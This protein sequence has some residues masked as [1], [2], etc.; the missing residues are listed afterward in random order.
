MRLPSFANS[1]LRWLGSCLFP[2]AAGALM[3][4]CSDDGT[5]GTDTDGP[6]NTIYKGQCGKSCDS[7]AECAQGLHCSADG[8]CFAECSPDGDE[9]G[10]GN[11]CDADGR[12]QSGAGGAG[13]SGGSLFGGNVNTGGD[14]GGGNTGGSC[15]EVV[16]DFEPQTP[17]VVLLIDQSGSMTADF[18]GQ[19]RWDVVYDVLMD[20]VDGVVAQLQ[21][22]VR[23]GLALYTYQSGPVCPQLIEV[24]P[25]ALNNHMT[26]DMVYAPENPLSNTP[27]GDSLAA[28]TPGLAA[29]AEE[30]PKLIMLATDGDP[31]R[32]EDPDGH[33]QISKDEATD[34]AQAAYALGIETVIIAVGDQVSQT[35]QQDMANAGKGLPIPAPDPC[36]DPALCAPTFEPTTKQEMI[37]T[38][39]DIINGQRTCVFQLDGEVIPGKECD[40][41]VRVNNMPLPCNDPNGWQLNSPT[42]IEFVGTACDTILNDPNVTIDASFPC[43]AVVPGPGGGP[44]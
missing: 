21:A 28:I 27:T 39:L 40:G 43:D 19:D 44:N 34:A 17:T 26:I 37:D 35:H 1:P 18:N 13:G 30:G 11:H 25:P 36:N 38:F 42:E 31:D 41:D 10:A 15:G 5:T 20:P 33:D 8:I 2:I 12:C 24:T 9:C 22:Q 32:C 23:F 4:S 6:C 16:V 29:F 3:W 14:M 7:D